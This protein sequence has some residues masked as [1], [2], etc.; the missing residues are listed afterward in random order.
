L[1]RDFDAGRRLG[2]IE[3]RPINIKQHRACSN[4]DRINKHHKSPMS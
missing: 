4:V 1:R 3:E 2:D